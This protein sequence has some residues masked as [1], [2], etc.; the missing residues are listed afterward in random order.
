VQV[1]SGR[2]L[3]STPPPPDC[4]SILSERRQWRSS[5]PPPP[6]FREQFKRP[7]KMRKFGEIDFEKPEIFLTSVCVFRV[8]REF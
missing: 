2:Q 4:R 3:I 1:H 6:K 8:A 5:K 7:A